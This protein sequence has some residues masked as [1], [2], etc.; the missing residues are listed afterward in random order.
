MIDAIK[1]IDGWQALTAAE[2]VST[3]SEYVQRPE[4]FHT[5]NSLVIALDQNV[6]LVEQLVG[7]MRVAGL[8]ASA[9]SLTNRGIDFGMPSVPVMLDSLASA[10]PELL[11]PELVLRLKRLGQWTR[12]ESFG[13]SGYVPTPEQVTA[14]IA[15]DTAQQ[16]AAEVSAWF[17]ARA[18][19]IREGLFEATIT[20]Q[21]QVRALLEGE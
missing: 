12:Y 5:F 2:I 19:L 14:A 21:D 11:K 7:A 1:Q 15:A 4:T 13:G 20:T 10:A 8:N 16:A 6:P 9:D 17:E 3:L 18:A